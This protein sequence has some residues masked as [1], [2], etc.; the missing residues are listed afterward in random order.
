MNKNIQNVKNQKIIEKSKLSDDKSNE[1]I[2]IK[3]SILK[4]DLIYLTFFALLFVS[5]V[6]TLVNYLQDFQ[7]TVFIDIPVIVDIISIIFLEFLGII[8]VVKQSKLKETSQENKK[9]W[10]LYFL[11]LFLIIPSIIA[12]SIES[13][14]KQLKNKQINNE[15]KYINRYANSSFLYIAISFY[16]FAELFFVLLARYNLLAYYLEHGMYSSFW[17]RISFF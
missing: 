17:L 2:K 12:I 10:I 14:K 7:N 5:L 13:N 6:L 16:F 11:G 1:L 15:N 9:I 8:L 3:K 4:I